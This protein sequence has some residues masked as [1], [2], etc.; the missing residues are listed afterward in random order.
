MH[1][2]VLTTFGHIK[3]IFLLSPLLRLKNA[4]LLLGEGQMHTDM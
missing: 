1:A 4:S 3:D 2:H